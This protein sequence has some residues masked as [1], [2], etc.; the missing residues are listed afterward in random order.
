MMFQAVGFT[1][2]CTLTVLEGG[3]QLVGVDSYRQQP[4]CDF[5]R[6]CTLTKPF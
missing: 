5:L 2:F 1:G 6:D 3:Q 4:H